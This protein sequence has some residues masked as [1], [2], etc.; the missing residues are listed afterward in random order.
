MQTKQRIHRDERTGG[1]QLVELLQL[2]EAGLAFTA[3]TVTAVS[4]PVMLLSGEP[5]P[6]IDPVVESVV[7]KEETPEL[8]Q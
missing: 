3:V 8:K 5:L 1:R 7:N 6:N 4:A 2:L